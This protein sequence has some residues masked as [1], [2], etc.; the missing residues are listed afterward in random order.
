MRILMN[1]LSC[2]SGGAVAYLRNLTPRLHGLFAESP[3]GNQLRILAHASQSDLLSDVP[4][5]AL[6]LV[7]GRRPLGYRRLLWEKRHLPRIAAE[8]DVDVVFVPYQVGMHVKGLRH[9]FMLRN[10][11]PFFY[12]GYNYGWRGGLRNNL[13]HRYSVRTLRMADRVIAVS[14]FAHDWLVHSMNVRP[15][16][17]RTVYHGRD[18]SFTPEGN[19]DGDRQLLTQIGVRNGFLLTC[20]SMLPYRRF[21]DVIAA[22]ALVA[23]PSGNGLQLV[24]A[25]SGNERRYSEMVRRL[26]AQSLNPDRIVLPGHVDRLTMQALYRCCRICLV[27]TEVEACPNIAIEAMTIGCVIV[28]SNR[29]PLPAMFQGCSL[30]YN[31]RDIRQMAEQIRKASESAPLRDR[32]RAR[33]LSRATAFSWKRCAKDTYAALTQWP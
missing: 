3:G 19:A 7:N 2:V 26:A 24:I 33:A 31:A 18:E 4:E 16:R 23:D 6:I 1:C 14:Q 15:E 17:V 13:L 20:G 10:M 25:G 5:D 28:S 27:T 8:H 9:I 29:P 21:E 32:L 30:E 22:F 11:E 12:R